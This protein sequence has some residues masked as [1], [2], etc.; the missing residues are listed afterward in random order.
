MRSI[1]RIHPLVYGFSFIA[2]FTAS[3]IEFFVIST[4]IMI[5]EIGHSL[6]VLLWKG[7][8]KEI[9]IYPLGGISKFYIDRNISFIKEFLILIAGPLFQCLA[10]F[11]LIFLFPNRM[12][13]I[14]SYHYKILLFNL[15]PIYPLD[16]GK[17][18]FL[19]FQKWF[20]WKK[21]FQ[22]SIVIGYV[23]VLV[24]L[25]FEEKKWNFWIMI[26]LLI[27][28]LIKEHRQ[29]SYQ[30]QKFLL[31]RYLHSYSFPKWKLIHHKDDFYRGKYHLIEEEKKYYWEKEYFKKHFK[32]D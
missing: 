24:M 20:P 19:C 25:L 9:V 23:L 21:S 4:L 7:T 31:E 30:Y 26:L 3:F 11:L 6:M 16:G 29:L 22:I 18:L 17:L 14:Q 5:H 10:F 28:L 15:L 27:V 12:N 8:I 13:L 32:K 1:F 2:V